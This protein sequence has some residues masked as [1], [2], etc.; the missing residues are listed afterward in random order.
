MLRRLVGRE[1]LICV[2]R[3]NAH[4][5]PERAIPSAS[6][7]EAAVV[8]RTWTAS[9]VWALGALT[10]IETAG[11][12]LGMGRT[13]AYEL[14]RRGHFPVVVLQHGRRMV[15]PVRGL[16]AALDIVSEEPST[17]DDTH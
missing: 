1:I 7:Q 5:D 8:R 4:V 9:E 11:S 3:S 17:R 6:R 10:D 2:D 15:V 13:K 12:V 14:A 16:L